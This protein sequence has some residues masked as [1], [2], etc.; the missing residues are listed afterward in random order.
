MTDGSCLTERICQKPLSLIQI[1]P[2][3]AETDNVYNIFIS[4][5]VRQDVCIGKRKIKDVAEFKADYI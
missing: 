4:S 3:F 5:L 2:G 1:L